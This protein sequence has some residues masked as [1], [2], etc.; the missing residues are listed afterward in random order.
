MAT[1]DPGRA[2][3]KRGTLKLT[4][5]ESQ[6]VL[7]TLM[8]QGKLREAQIRAALRH[9]K[10]E[11]AR[12]REQLVS[13]ESIGAARNLSGPRRRA[14]GGRPTAPKR[15]KMSPRVQSLRR[16]QG[17]YMSFVRG[18]AVAE[19]ARVRTVREKDGMGAAIRLAASLAKKAS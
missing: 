19:K 7:T 5:N 4:A 15:R 13:L 18:L 17:R 9:R 16:Q 8:A 11:I 6:Y 3:R 12:L 10:D 2:S 1:L 14:S